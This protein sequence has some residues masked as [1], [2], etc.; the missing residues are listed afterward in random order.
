MNFTFPHF[1]FILLHFSA[2]SKVLFY[3]FVWTLSIIGLFCWIYLFAYMLCLILSR[4]PWLLLYVVDA[5][6]HPWTWH[7]RI[8]LVFF[9]NPTCSLP[10]DVTWNEAF[11]I[12][13]LLDFL[14]LFLPFLSCFFFLL[15][16]MFLVSS[17]CWVPHL[18]WPFWL[19][20]FWESPI[21]ATLHTVR[22]FWMSVS[23]MDHTE[24]PRDAMEE[25]N[26]G[27]GNLYSMLDMGEATM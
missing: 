14:L 15:I 3:C 22:N 5:W 25:Y 20:C 6:L 23:R 13:F 4:F 27:W 1:H 16:P 26:W 24:T 2:D 17:W 10:M 11:Y 7:I 19:R 9:V 18:G 8:M 21:W 12:H